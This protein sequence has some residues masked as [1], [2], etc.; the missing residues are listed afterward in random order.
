MSPTIPSAN[1]NPSPTHPSLIKAYPPTLT[2]PHRPIDPRQQITK[3]YP[4]P[5]PSPSLT[6][7]PPQS[8]PLPD[9]NSPNAN[10]RILPPQTPSLTAILR[11]RSTPA[12]TPTPRPTVKPRR[13]IKFARLRAG[14]GWRAA[15]T[16]GVAGWWGVGEEF[17]GW[18]GAFVCC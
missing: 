6:L 5:K 14:A 8:L 1:P 18:G 2:S 4:P 7:H 13:W 3:R 15:R 11:T 10:K 9:T 16:G 17:G 12:P